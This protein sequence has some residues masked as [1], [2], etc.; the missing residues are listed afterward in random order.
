MC[1]ST[2]TC[3]TSECSRFLCF[4]PA[5]ESSSKQSCCTNLLFPF[6]STLP[7]LPFHFSFPLSGLEFPWGPKPFV[8][9]VAGPLLR[10]N[11]QT[12][13]SSSLEGHYVGVY[14]SAH[15][16]SAQMGQ[17]NIYLPVK[18]P[19]PM[20][21]KGKAGSATIRV[22]HDRCERLF[23]LTAVCPSVATPP[24][25]H[26]AFVFHCLACLLMAGG[27]SRLTDSL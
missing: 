1:S 22:G 27:G 26:Q 20:R 16:V 15:W 11:R 2:V 9:V 17:K 6:S 19:P 24:Q 18:A 21:G 23:T 10:N 13:D 4:L 7:F 3:L 25:W 8:E 12:T 14:F 5:V